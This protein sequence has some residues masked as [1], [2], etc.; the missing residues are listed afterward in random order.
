[1]DTLFAIFKNALVVAVSVLCVIL[2]SRF[3]HLG[4]SSTVYTIDMNKVLR[5]HQALV[6]EAAQN[7]F[8]AALN[9]KGVSSKVS[10][11]IQTVAGGELV[12]VAP[13]VA[14]SLENDI[15]DQVILELG[16][17]IPQNASVPYIDKSIFPDAEK[18]AQN[19]PEEFY[20][21]FNEYLENKEKQEEIE[22]AKEK[23]EEVLPK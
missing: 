19:D 4:G 21:R 9:L 22:A 8:D 7:S 6:S 14:S 13:V 10:A 3:G 5:A 15:T 2:L 23:L 17:E 18:A 16:L 12:L 20:K 1:M 11:A